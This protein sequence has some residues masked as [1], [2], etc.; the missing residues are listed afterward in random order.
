MTRRILLGHIAGAHGI[1]GEVLIKSYTA[2]LADIGA[3]GPLT[4]ERGQAPLMI[5]QTRISNKGVIARIAGVRDRNAAEALKGRALAVERTALPAPGD[6]D[7]YHADLI[8]LAAVAPDGSVLGTV[9][10]VQNFGA[11]DLLELSRAETLETEFVPFTNACVP[12]VDVTAGRVTIV[13]PETTGDQAEER[14][15]GPQDA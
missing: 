8:G 2:E 14:A 3:Y 11:G 4:D 15:S 6:G 1:K 7:Y 10:A 5:E 13:L 12:I 9:V